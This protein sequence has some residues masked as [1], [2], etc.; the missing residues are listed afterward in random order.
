MQSTGA[1]ILLLAPAPFML[2]PALIA[3]TSRKRR[4]FVILG[5]DLA[6]FASIVAGILVSGAPILR[7]DGSL[8]ASLL[9]LGWSLKRD[10]PSADALDEPVTLA[11][12]DTLWPKAFEAE[13][14]RICEAL[15]ISPDAIEHIGSTAV[16]GL[17]AKPVVD[18]MLGL[19][20]YPPDDSTVSR[21]VILG[22][23][24][25]GEAGVAGRRYLRMRE[26]PSFNLHVVQRD[27]EHWI[28]NLRLRNYLRGDAIAR[29]RYADAKRAALAKGDRLLAYSSAKEPVIAELAAAAGR[30]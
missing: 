29:E 22:F 16:P 2:L 9:L 6:L 23:Q 24:D 14:S 10:P 30:E 28:N 7:L 4:R 19:P 3:F 25:L 17:I 26:G 20:R 15:M 11:P 5:L 21:L 13:R 8:I 12:Y 27:G 1:L 18:L